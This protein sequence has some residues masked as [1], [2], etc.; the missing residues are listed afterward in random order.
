MGGAKSGNQFW[1]SDP[2]KK[3]FWNDGTKPFR[4]FL[5]AYYGTGGDLNVDEIHA[6][7]FP[8]PRKVVFGTHRKG[9]QR[10][11]QSFGGR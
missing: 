8:L 4:H 10:T 1:S 9:F 2:R 7:S 5:K 6:R 11:F 3:G